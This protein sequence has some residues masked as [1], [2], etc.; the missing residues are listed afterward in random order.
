MKSTNYKSIIVFGESYRVPA[1][2]LIIFDIAGYEN[3]DLIN[4][5]THNT[6]I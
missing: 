6:L 1:N 2:V 5:A 4:I 3:N